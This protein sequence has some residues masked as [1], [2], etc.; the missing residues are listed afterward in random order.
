MDWLDAQAPETLHLSVITLGEI[1]KGIN[2]LAR[3]QRKSSLQTWLSQTLPTRFAGRI[4]GIEI[5]TMLLWGELVGRLEQQG[6][7]LPVMDS[8][9]AA[10]ALQHSLAISSPAMKM[11]LLKQVLRSSIRG[12]VK[13][14]RSLTGSC[15]TVYN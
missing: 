6:R 14:D 3:S 11:I 5:A 1:A 13:Y 12:L 15:R 2:K 4:L 9:I 7:S 8:L 10:I